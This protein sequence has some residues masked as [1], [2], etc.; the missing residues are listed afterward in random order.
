VRQRKTVFEGTLNSVAHWKFV[1]T[2]RLVWSSTGAAVHPA[3]AIVESGERD[4]ASP[5]CLEGVGPVAHTDSRG[6]FRAWFI[7]RGSQTPIARPA[8]ISI[9]LRVAR[10]KWKPYVISVEPCRGHAVSQHELEI[11]VGAVEI[12]LG[13]PVYA[14]DEE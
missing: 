14:E 6:A 8:A 10:G 12:E 5:F 7:V 2:G 1:V 3:E 13:Q 9:F 11:D 4:D